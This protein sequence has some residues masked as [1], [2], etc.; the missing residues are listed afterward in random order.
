[1]D[2]LYIVDGIGIA[3]V[4]VGICMTSSQSSLVCFL[5]LPACKNSRDLQT[6]AES[7]VEKKTGLEIRDEWEPCQRG[8]WSK[9]QQPHEVFIA[10]S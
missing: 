10:S 2:T 9:Q 8:D 7:L 4:G 3:A 6:S 5:L 1:M